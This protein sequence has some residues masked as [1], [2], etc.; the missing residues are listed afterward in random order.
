MCLLGDFSIASNNCIG[1][2]PANTNCLISLVFTPSGPGVR[3]ATLTFTDD[4]PGSPQVLNGATIFY[5]TDGSTPTTSSPVYSSAFTLN[6]PTTVQA[7]AAAS[8]HSQSAAASAVYKFQTPSGTTTIL[9]TP[10][11]VPTGSSKQLQL[12]PIQLALT[13]R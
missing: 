6:T 12:N 1:S 13:V 7:L 11:A 3:A 10:A 5:T 2:L 4:A 9:V 8:G